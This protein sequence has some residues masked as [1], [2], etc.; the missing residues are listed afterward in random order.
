MQTEVGI[1]EL[2][3]KLS[4]Y[5]RRVRAGET[6]TITDRGTPVGRIVPIAQ[7]T[8]A[9]LES[10]VEAG[11]IERN[12]GQLRDMEPVARVKGNRTVAELLVE[13]RV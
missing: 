5:M 1:R 6:I 12:E 10:L 11:L 7:T 13:N 3:Q 4:A 2:K 8:Q 9:R